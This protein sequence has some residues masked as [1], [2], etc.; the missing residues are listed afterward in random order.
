MKGGVGVCG[1]GCGV[2]RRPAISSVVLLLIL[3]KE[4][5]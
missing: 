5:S 2:V 4:D 3:K 1:G